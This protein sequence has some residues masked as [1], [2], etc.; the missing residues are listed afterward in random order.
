MIGWLLDKTKPAPP[1]WLEG[2]LKSEVG[3]LQ[4]TS[5]LDNRSIL[6]EIL[7]STEDDTRIEALIHKELHTS[8]LNHFKA[9]DVHIYLEVTYFRPDRKSVV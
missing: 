6:E 7:A 2:L 1:E 9:K 8:L 3:R 4:A 5:P